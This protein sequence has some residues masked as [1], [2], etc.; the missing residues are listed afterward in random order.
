MLPLVSAAT[1][2][3]TILPGLHAQYAYNVCH[4]HAA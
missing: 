3:I 1:L 4:A 2:Q